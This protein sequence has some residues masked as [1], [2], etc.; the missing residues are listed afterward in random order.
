MIADSLSK[1]EILNS[2]LNLHYEN[3]I[4]RFPGTNSLGLNHYIFIRIVFS[5]Y[6]T[7]L[8]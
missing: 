7:G 6:W 1:A 8:V 2:N 3:K 5:L 4:P